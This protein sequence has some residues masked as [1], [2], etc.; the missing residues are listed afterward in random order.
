MLRIAA[1]GRGGRGDG[2][3][4]PQHMPSFH[5]LVHGRRCCSRGDRAPGLLGGWFWFEQL[6]G[7]RAVASSQHQGRR[8]F[9]WQLRHQAG[10]HLL[11]SPS[12]LDGGSRVLVQTLMPSQCLNKRKDA[13]VCGSV[14]ELCQ[15]SCTLSPGQWEGDLCWPTPWHC[16]CSLRPK[17][18]YAH[19]YPLV[20]VAQQHKFFLPVRHVGK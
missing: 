1:G 5:A 19:P 20:R 8:F 6:R 4:L 14:A 16:P 13:V 15:A 3:P 11:P 10:S 9:R 2:E 7:V 12:S 17:P 18:G